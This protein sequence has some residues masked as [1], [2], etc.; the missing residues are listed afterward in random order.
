[1]AG[2]PGKGAQTVECVVEP[3][4]AQHRT[5]RRS[6]GVR[7]QGLDRVDMA[8][9][10]G[11]V[12]PGMPGRDRAAECRHHLF[13][14]LLRQVVR[15]ERARREARKAVD[16]PHRSAL[17]VEQAARG[18]AVEDRRAKQPEH[19]VAGVEAAAGLDPAH[20]RQRQRGLLELQAFDGEEV[21]HQR[22]AR[23]A[24]EHVEQRTGVVA[25]V[26][27]E[28]DPAHVFGL[29]HRE[30]LLEPLLAM[31]RC[32]GVDD[33][34]FAAADDHRVHRQQQAVGPGRQVRDQEDVGSDRLGS[35]DGHGIER[36]GGHRELLGA[37]DEVVIV[38]VGA[39][40][41]IARERPPRSH[42]GAHRSHRRAPSTGHDQRTTGCR[43]RRGLP[44][45]NT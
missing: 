10:G 35:R 17:R 29:D 16:D 3:A 40:R 13:Q 26:V 41:G 36:G 44:M 38:A 31:H 1:M 39:R 9:I 28:E 14:Q 34:R 30:H 42:A 45:M 32:A 15:I 21:G 18:R 43:R 4:A 5:V 37:G 27:R 8:Q 11:R 12:E 2:A 23:A 24:L 33:H 25:V 7:A 22:G 6:D 19:A 20:A